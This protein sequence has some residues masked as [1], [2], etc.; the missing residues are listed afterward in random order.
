MLNEAEIK[1]DVEYIEKCV[2]E[3]IREMHNGI[4]NDKYPSTSDAKKLCEYV[5]QLDTFDWILHGDEIMKGI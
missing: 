3:I 2:K 4:R 1:K 5:I